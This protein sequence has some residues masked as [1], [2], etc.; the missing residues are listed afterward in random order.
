[1]HRIVPP[2]T[3]SKRSVTRFES[4][5]LLGTLTS[6]SLNQEVRKTR[7]LT[8]LS[9][10]SP[11]L[12]TQLHESG[13]K[14]EIMSKMKGTMSAATATNANTAALALYKDNLEVRSLLS[15]SIDVSAS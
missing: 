1:M 6:R 2:S 14:T 15:A 9:R 12:T 10:A 7:V 11:L 13:F 8:C 3:R 4:S 5:W